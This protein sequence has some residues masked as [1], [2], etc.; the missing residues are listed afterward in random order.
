MG[1]GG[2]G[3]WGRRGGGNLHL[4]SSWLKSISPRARL[5]EFRSQPPSPFPVWPQA[6]YHTSLGFRVLI[7]K[8]RAWVYLPPRDVTGEMSCE[9]GAWPLGN[10]LAPRP[11]GVSAWAWVHCLCTGQWD[12]PGGAS[13]KEPA[14]HCGRCKRLRVRSLGWEDLEEGMATHSRT[15]AWRSPMDRGAW[16]AT[17]H[18][19][20]E[21][22]TTERLSMHTPFL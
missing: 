17:V 19:V 15:L 13:G 1:G 4:H 6:S 18:G 12:F 5:L 16:Q 2:G 11:R 21:S 20:A 9:H 10:P 22:D 3:G 14:C 8:T 7:C